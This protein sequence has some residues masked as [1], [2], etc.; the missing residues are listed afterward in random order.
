MNLCVF[1]EGTGQG[2]AGRI[3]NVTRMRDLCREDSRQRLHLE[4]GS[5][6][7]SAQVK[8]QMP[9]IFRFN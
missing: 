7:L 5:L 9:A 8:T 4:A 2:V 6:V 3:T 1:F